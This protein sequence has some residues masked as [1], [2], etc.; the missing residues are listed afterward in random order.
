MPSLRSPQDELGFLKQLS[1]SGLD[2]L[3]QMPA[4]ADSL[5][6]LIPAFSM[7]MIRV[8]ERCAP[9]HHYSEY[10]DEFSHQLF[11]E[12]G[13]HFSARTDD[14]AAFSNLLARPV[15]FG[16]LVRPSSAFFAGA[17]YQHLFRRNGIHHVLDV[18]LR[19]GAG[20]LGILGIFREESAR[21]FTRS[22]VAMVAQL[23]PHLVHA[24]A[25]RPTLE[26]LSQADYDEIGSGLLVVDRAGRIQFASPHARL[27]LEDASGG[28]ERAAIATEG[29]LP[30]ACRD[31]L[32]CWENA[33]RD[34]PLASVEAAEVPTTCLPLP[35]GRLRLRAYALAGD[36][37][38][39]GEN[40]LIGVQ[41]S[42]EMDHELRVR[43]ALGRAPITP[44]QRRIALSLWR[45]HD[46]PMIRA[47]L[48]VSAG[49]LKSYQKD[50]YAR[51]GVSSVAQ[52]RKLLDE[53]ARAIT[54]DLTRH[55]PRLDDTPGEG[56]SNPPR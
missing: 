15:P 9:L 20:P 46:T 11:A 48:G 6:R 49:T 10:F 54:F 12:S 37:N 33:Q 23:Y 35:G 47:E 4:V 28:P 56:V 16:N 8:D 55:L 25:A 26:A 50:L 53:Q 51:L 40:A 27:W 24:C 18:A 44:Q 38:S 34:R 52:L 19:D 22:D 7:S 39:S 1:T 36:A 2:L 21:P 17:T 5:R 30:N 3:T 43:T 42:L 45:G 29:R 32:R 41:L 14:P 31:L 13:H